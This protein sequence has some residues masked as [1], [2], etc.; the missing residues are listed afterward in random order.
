MRARY[1]L[2][3]G[4]ARSWI[5]LG[6]AAALAAPA[7]SFDFKATDSIDGSL[8]SLITAGFSQRLR[9]QNA[10]LVAAPGTNGFFTGFQDAHTGDLNYNKGDLFALYLKG[11][12]EMLLKFPDKYKFFVR[13]SWLLDGKASDTQF[14][15]LDSAA[16]APAARDLR[17]YD[18]WASKDFELFGNAARWRL[19]R[20][21]INWGESLFVAGGVNAT[22]AID[23]YRLTYPGVPLKEVVLPAE[24]VSLAFSPARGVNVEGYYQFRWNQ[25]HIVPVGTFFSTSDYIGEGKGT[26]WFFLYDPRYAATHGGV[27]ASSATGV[28]F[29]PKV[30]NPQQALAL[31]NANGFTFCA[32][33]DVVGTVGAGGVCD[34]GLVPGNLGFNDYG[35][36]F[37]AGDQTPPVG[38][39]FGLSAHYKPQGSALDFGLYYE[40]F[41]EKQPYLR[42]L[43]APSLYSLI[44][45]QLVYPA[46]H[47][48]YGASV[49]VLAGQWAIG[50][51]ISYRPKDPILV[52]PFSCVDLNP[53]FA[54][55]ADCH[56]NWAT[57][58]DAHKWQWN[59]TW[60]R[61]VNP[62]DSD[63]AGWLVRHAGA[64]ASNIQGEF[65]VV[66]YPGVSNHSYQGVGLLTDLSYDITQPSP[67]G[68]DKNARH[69]GTA[70]SFGIV[71]YLDMTWD[72]TVIPGWQVIP[73]ITWSLGIAGDTPNENY[74][75]FQG[76]LA[77]TYAL[78]L[79]QDKQSW[80]ASI[81]YVT[82][83]G[84]DPSILRNFYADRDWWGASLTYTF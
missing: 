63:I 83:R 82:Y 15:P 62:S 23:Q 14:A 84:G 76:F 4:S 43:P 17:L 65:A 38:K 75:W 60:W 28:P 69:F 6:A 41:H 33:N 25:N 50:S 55:G 24:M 3:A 32:A 66:H 49:N 56:G 13:G 42:Y 52:D 67:S 74:T 29:G 68:I 9:E 77:T 30:T 54:G 19:G 57:Y 34:P 18:L 73:N 5:A 7:Y 35:V 70:D 2:K 1:R 64:Q 78:T 16:R 27:Y 26:N 47:N 22:A 72:S 61:A 48:L 8:I 31:A 59:T 36:P 11:S 40:H 20:Q 71:Q 81:L 37:I 51:E 58:R 53:A 39:Q 79:I 46:N 45:Q 12:E 44:G 80:S 21:V 10:E